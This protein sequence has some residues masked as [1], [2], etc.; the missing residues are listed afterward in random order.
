MCQV[1]STLTVT[2]RRES[3]ISEG[4]IH[5]YMSVY[6]CLIVVYDYTYY[7]SFF[8]STEYAW[9]NLSFVMLAVYFF[10]TPN[11][12]PLT[13]LPPPLPPYPLTPLPPYPLTPLPHPYPYH[14]SPPIHTPILI[15]IPYPYL[16]PYPHP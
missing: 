1:I 6:A 14:L 7:V 4:L 12:Y 16:Y 2:N 3:S 13:P 15:L 9:I 8:S 11:P 5:H 10:S